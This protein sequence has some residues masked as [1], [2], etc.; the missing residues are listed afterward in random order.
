MYHNTHIYHIF[1][2]PLVLVCGVA[3][4]T[5]FATIDIMPRLGSLLMAVGCRTMTL[6]AYRC[7]S[8]AVQ[9]IPA[10]RVFEWL[11]PLVIFAELVL[12]GCLAADIISAPALDAVDCE[13]NEF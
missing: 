8:S 4:Y 1:A 5:I 9:E 13:L 3:S 6:L 12:A 2:I 11:I 10:W 7:F